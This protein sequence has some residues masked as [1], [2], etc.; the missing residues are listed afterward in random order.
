MENF[1]DDKEYFS[2][3]SCLICP[4]PIS[5]CKYCSISLNECK[6]EDHYLICQNVSYILI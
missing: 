3:N 4:S 5:K 6:L 1:I 2:L